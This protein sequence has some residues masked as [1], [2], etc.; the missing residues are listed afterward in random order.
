[1]TLTNAVVT[2]YEPG[3]F[4]PTLSADQ[5]IYEPGRRITGEHGHLGL[6]DYSL[7]AIPKFDRI[8]RLYLA[9]LIRIG[10]TVL[11]RVGRR[12]PGRDR[13]RTGCGQTKARVL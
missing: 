3:P 10:V 9:V 13:T 6:G 8:F 2:Y 1:M 4:A 11:R 7:F 5:I 12:E